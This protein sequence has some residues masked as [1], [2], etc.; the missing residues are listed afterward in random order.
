MASAIRLADTN[1]SEHVIRD[2]HTPGS[3]YTGY[4][5]YYPSAM[6]SFAGASM[7]DRKVAK[8]GVGRQCCKAE[9]GAVRYLRV[10]KEG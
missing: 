6:T 2:G 10:R 9:P 7:G 8:R 3:P 4:E 1:W 5:R